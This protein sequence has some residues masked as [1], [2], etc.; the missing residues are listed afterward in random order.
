MLVPTNRSA[1][2]RM[3]SVNGPQSPRLSTILCADSGKERAKRAVYLA[4]VAGR[5]VRRLPG[6]G[7]SL[8]RL[9]EEAQQFTS[10][11]PFSSPSMHRLGFL[12]ATY[13][14]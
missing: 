4:G 5:V 6:E 10:M 9:L 13:R 7:W 11:D 14:R 3:S 8:A 1:E 2:T 12:K